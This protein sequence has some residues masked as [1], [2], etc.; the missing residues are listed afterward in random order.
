MMEF[1]SKQEWR[2]IPMVAV[3]R[4]CR[5][6]GVRAVGR[7]AVGVVSVGLVA[8]RPVS[9]GLYGR[10]GVHLKRTQA[11]AADLWP[12]RLEAAPGPQTVRLIRA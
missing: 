3:S 7:V 6:I 5:A 9:V 11:A 8:V 10:G 2:G 1:L 12:S 4:S